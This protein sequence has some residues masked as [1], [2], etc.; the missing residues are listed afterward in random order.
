[1]PASLA[2]G[3]VVGE[4]HLDDALLAGLGALQA[5]DEPGNE[6][7]LADDQLHV[8][9]LAALELLPVDAADEIDG[10]PVAV[11]GGPV[12]LRLVA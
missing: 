7:A 6:T 4:L 2:A 5:F 9:A 3:I 8:L 1:M 11:A 10:Q 12:R